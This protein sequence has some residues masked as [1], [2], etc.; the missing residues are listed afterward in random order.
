MSSKSPTLMSN[1]NLWE[2]KNLRNQL[3]GAQSFLR[4]C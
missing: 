1:A 3:Y 4:S 2:V